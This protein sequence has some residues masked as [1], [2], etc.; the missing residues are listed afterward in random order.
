MSSEPAREHGDDPASVWR[1]LANPVRRTILDLLRE[2]PR[3]TGSLAGEFAPD[4]SRFAVMQH[5]EILC[6]AGL[7]T[8]RREGRRRFNHLNAVPLR[9]VYERWV[10]RFADEMAR[11]TMALK[12]YVEKEEGTMAEGTAGRAIR[13][14]NEIR[15]AATP[16]T[17]FEAATD[18]QLDW[19][20]YNYGGERLQDIVFEH[21]VG[22]RVYEDWGEGAGILYGTVA[23]YDP[24]RAY[25]TRGHLRGG[26][27]LEQWYEAEATDEGTLLKQSMV[28]FGDISDEMADAIRSHGDLSRFA[29]EFRAFCER[30]EGERTA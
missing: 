5:L 12:R 6:E 10:G 15:V 20:P 3:T 23:Y 29:D 19:Y 28:A 14:A 17:V 13:L 18:R 30:L 22:G 16:Q 11:S 26:I 25:C 27:T 1:A 4:L 7:V 2:G 21:Q 8:V 24:P 9:E